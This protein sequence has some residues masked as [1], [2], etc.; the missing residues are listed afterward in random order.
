LAKLARRIYFDDRRLQLVLL[1][2][3]VLLYLN[4]AAGPFGTPEKPVLQQ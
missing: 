4:N 1:A 3:M 2:F